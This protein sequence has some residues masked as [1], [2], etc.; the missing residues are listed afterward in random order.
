[1]GLPILEIE[2]LINILNIF[3][4]H[5]PIGNMVG[6]DIT[7]TCYQYW[8][9]GILQGLEEVLP[10]IRGT[11]VQLPEW[12]SQIQVAWVDHCT[13]LCFLFCES[14]MNCKSFPQALILLNCLSLS[15][16]VYAHPTPQPP[17]FRPPLISHLQFLLVFF[18]VYYE[19]VR[20]LS[21][22]QLASR[23]QN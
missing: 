6:D 12:R 16:T 17:L 22:W 15:I 5:F 8:L 7:Y 19:V 14:Q 4:T 13:I 18:N 10:H 1:M 23:H 3:Y 20:K 2:Y 11:I 9:R 21:S